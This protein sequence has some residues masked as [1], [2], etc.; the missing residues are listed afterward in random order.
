MILFCR[1]WRR[2]AQSRTC[3][4]IHRLTSESP[5]IEITRSSTHFDQ[6]YNRAYSSANR[7]LGGLERLSHLPSESSL[8][9]DRR[10]RRNGSVLRILSTKIAQD[11]TRTR[12]KIDILYSDN[13]SCVITSAADC[14]SMI[15]LYLL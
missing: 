6:D 10:R 3:S 7:G 14:K 8:F 11:F 5:S 13:A 12:N 9:R 1:C 2:E 4:R 15:R